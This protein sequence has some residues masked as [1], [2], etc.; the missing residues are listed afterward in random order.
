M[1]IR[2]I[3]FLQSILLSLPL[4]LVFEFVFISRVGTISQKIITENV[5]L[6]FT[7]IFFIIIYIYIDNFYLIEKGIKFILLLI[8]I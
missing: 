5:F 4:G 2:K 7:N 8:F 6:F 3:N 1:K